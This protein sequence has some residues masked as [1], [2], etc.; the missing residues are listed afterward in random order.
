[1]GTYFGQAGQFLVQTIF[2]L[3]IA[4][5]VLRILLQLVR[6]NFFN[7][8]CQFIIK[9]TNPPLIPF[10]RILPNWGQLDIAATLFAWL[11]SMVK[12]VLVLALVSASMSALQLIAISAL[13][14]LSLCIY[15]ITIVIIVQ[16]ILSWVQMFSPIQSNPL[17]PLLY[18]LSRP[19]VEPIRRFIPPVA[20]MDFSAFVALIALQLFKI[21]VMNPLYVAA[22]QL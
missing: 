14:L 2:G 18:A 7:P 20:G 16:V 9:L 1:M 22:N 11:L 8:V 3:Y 12:L 10:R 6:A 15:I 17:Q 13:D 4:I 21:L 19:I 5:V